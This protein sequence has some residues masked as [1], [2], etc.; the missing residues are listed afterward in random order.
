MVSFRTQGS[1][2]SSYSVGIPS[3]SRTL[4]SNEVLGKNI[5]SLSLSLNG[6]Q[7]VVSTINLSRD[8]LRLGDWKRSGYTGR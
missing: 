1:S 8:N 3:V 5:P 4:Q 2:L 6:F 7:W